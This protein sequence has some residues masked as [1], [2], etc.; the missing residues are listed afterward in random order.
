M[1]RRHVHAGR[2]A[3][4]EIP[5]KHDRAA[6]IRVRSFGEKTDVQRRAIA[7]ASGVVAT[8]AIPSYV[9]TT[10]KIIPFAFAGQG[11]RTR[12]IV[13]ADKKAWEPRFGI[14]WSPKMK[15]F[16]IDLEKRSLVVRAG[17]GV[18][19]APINGNNRSANPDFGGFTTASTLGPTAAAPNASSGGVD[20]TGP[21]RF[22]GNNALQG[23]S[24]PLSVLL[25]TDANGLVFNKSIAIPGIAVDF[26]DPGRYDR[27]VKQ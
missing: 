20:N 25:G 26:A 17:F 9:P 15:I 2:G 7:T 11:G 12:S 22:T 24:T 3:V 8:D 1:L 4:S 19:H 6:R 5:R 16:G 18:A 13:P 14:A 23:S 27:R 21:I 10:T